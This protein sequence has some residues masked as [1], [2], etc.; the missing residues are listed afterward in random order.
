MNPLPYFMVQ[1]YECPPFFRD[2]WLND[3]HDM[4]HTDAGEGSSRPSIVT[5]DYRFVYLGRKVHPGPLSP[6]SI[7]QGLPI[8]CEL[9]KA[10][11]AATYIVHRSSPP[12][13]H[14]IVDI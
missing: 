13:I 5:S 9:G 6:P 8:S 10:C 7:P 14:E 1:A 4:L 12:L 3:Y 11:T 2:D